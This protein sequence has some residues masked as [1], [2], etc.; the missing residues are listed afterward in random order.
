MKKKGEITVFLALML[1]VISSF[2]IVLARYVRIF[3]A[4]S[5]AVYVVDNAVRSCFAEY[6]R[7][8]FERFHILLVDSSYKNTENG[9]DRV[10]DHFA[11]YL[12]NSLSQSEL[13]DAAVTNSKSATDGRYLYD[14]AVRYEKERG[15]IDLRLVASGDDAYFLSYILDVFGD[16]DIP[17]KD[18][19]RRG[20]IE[21]LLYGCESDDE[22]IS[23]AREDCGIC[24]EIPYG[25]FLIRS[26]ED[27]DMDVL[28]DRFG[29]LVTEYMR[30][31]GSPGFDLEECFFDMTFSADV[32][33]GAGQYTIT[34]KYSYDAEGI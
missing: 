12:R 26:L 33:N 20:E 29:D 25:D 10:E 23:W 28:V 6:N 18:A 30:K 17:C 34:R 11:M 8:L 7:A 5:E 13:L 14:A 3:T 4:K 32:D 27:E 16:D 9:T 19:A 24:E 21:Y 15:G 1:S 2:I 31:N 22:N